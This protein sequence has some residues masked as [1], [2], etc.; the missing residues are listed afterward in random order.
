MKKM[1]IKLARLYNFFIEN[2]LDIKIIIVGWIMNL[3]T[4]LFKFDSILCIWD[5]LFV[6]KVSLNILE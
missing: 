3:F 2:N 5:I 1:K 4:R 6:N